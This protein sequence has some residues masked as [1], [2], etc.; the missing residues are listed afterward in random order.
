M[1]RTALRAHWLQAQADLEG[2]APEARCGHVAVAVHNQEVWNEEFLIIHGRWGSRAGYD[3]SPRRSLGSVE[4]GI[5]T[6]TDRPRPLPS[7]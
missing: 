1:A 2:E 3:V 7:T 5:Y 6:S 4:L